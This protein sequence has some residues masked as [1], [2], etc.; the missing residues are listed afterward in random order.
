MIT[1]WV[2]PVLVVTAVTGLMI[3]LAIMIRILT[4]TATYRT[5]MAGA[6]MPRRISA[7]MIRLTTVTRILTGT[8]ARTTSATAVMP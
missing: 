5:T 3:R 2:L 8:T 1:A 4:G 6:V 7:L